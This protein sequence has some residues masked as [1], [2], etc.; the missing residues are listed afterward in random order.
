MRQV[1]EIYT[2]PTFADCRAN[3]DPTLDVRDRLPGR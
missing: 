2:P 1:P 3:R